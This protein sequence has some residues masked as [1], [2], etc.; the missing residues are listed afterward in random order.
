GAHEPFALELGHGFAQRRAA[1]AKIRSEPP[2]VEPDVGPAAIDV[3]GRDRVFER[4]IGAAL[5]AIGA[6][7]GLDARR[8]RG[9]RRM[10]RGWA[11]DA[12]RTRVTITATHGSYT[13]F[14]NPAARNGGPCPGDAGQALGRP[15]CPQ[16]LQRRPGA[17]PRERPLDPPP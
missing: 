10:G 13:I 3:H 7:D 6:T 15:G 5:E 9:S 8:Y 2:L 11:P 17:Q 14:Q 1:D 4:G 12:G 16:P